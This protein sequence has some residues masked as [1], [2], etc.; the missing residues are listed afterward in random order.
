MEGALRWSWDLL[1]VSD[2]QL[3]AQLSV[4]LGGWTDEAAL[5]I[6]GGDTLALAALADH[7]LVVPG[8]RWR[9]LETVR[10]FARE[11][12]DE[13]DQRGEVSIEAVRERHA[14]YYLQKAQALYD[15]QLRYWPEAAPPPPWEPLFASDEANLRAAQGYWR[16]HRGELSDE[17]LLLTLLEFWR[18][19]N[20]GHRQEA[21]VWIERLCTEPLPEP[22]LLR[23]QLYATTGTWASWLGH[24]PATVC[25][26]WEGALVLS[27]ACQAPHLGARLRFLLGQEYV[28]NE[29]LERGKA[30]LEQ[31]LAQ[32]DL[33]QS[34]G[35]RLWSR[36]YLCYLSKD[37]AALDCELTQARK[38]PNPEA[39][40]YAARY[41]VRLAIAQGELTL[42]KA[43]AQEALA[44]LPPSDLT[45]YA[46]LVR[47]LNELAR[48][49]GDGVT[50]EAY[51]RQLLTRMQTTN[52]QAEST[53]ARVALAKA[54]Q[55]QQRYEEAQSTICE[56]FT[57]FG[58]LR[59]HYGQAQCIELL[60]TLATEQKRPEEAISLLSFLLRCFEE[61]TLGVNQ[62]TIRQT[63]QKLAS[64][65]ATLNTEQFQSAY[66]QGKQWSKE[67]MLLKLSN[68]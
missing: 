29:E 9:L 62:P 13:L 52:Q 5:V 8:E 50:A 39:F 65:R 7:S 54:Y 4:F 2:R 63:T 34:H 48:L 23:A 22:S 20:S 56:A 3:L 26:L 68:V 12:L 37:V 53:W 18:H 45:G 55:L 41:R 49:E 16:T 66:E 61:K 31:V 51:A 58:Q 38:L 40:C 32:E 35:E 6:T 10:V 30:L 57:D 27:D 14:T 19:R 21:S 25:Q 59:D 43:L 64:L 47:R 36:L 44:F 11:R 15:G 33:P 28:Q 1:P 46:D 17:A 60:A 67:L 24:S 42:G